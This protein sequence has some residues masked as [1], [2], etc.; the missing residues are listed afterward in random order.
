MNK[1]QDH[2]NVMSAEFI[3][4]FEIWR[5]LDLNKFS[6]LFPSFATGSSY[7]RLKSEEKELILTQIKLS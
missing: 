4:L 5:K 6:G 3:F 2:K 1:E 7:I